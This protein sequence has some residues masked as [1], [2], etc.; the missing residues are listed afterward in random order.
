MVGTLLPSLLGDT[1]GLAHK[2]DGRTRPNPLVG[3]VVLD[4]QGRQFQGY[5]PRYGSVHAE[6]VALDLAG[7]AARGSTLYC[8]LEPCCHSGQGKHQP[9]CTGKIIAA[10]VQKVVVGQLDPN[11]QVRGK[12]LDQLRRAGIEVELASDPRPFLRLN[13]GFN[14]RH[15]LD[16]PYVHLKAALSL[17]GKI[18]PVPGQGGWISGPD[19]RTEV[20]DL[21]SRYDG[22]GVGVGTVLSD[23][24]Q[25]SV[26][27]D[28]YKGE[29]PRAV[30]FDRHLRTPL[31]S[32]LVQQRPGE[33]FIVGG[34]G[35]NNTPRGREL[36]SRGVEVLPSDG[37]LAGQL[38]ALAGV[39]IQTLLVEGGAEILT[40]FFVSELWDEITLYFAPK[41][42]G[43]GVPLLASGSG[44][45]QPRVPEFEDGEWRILGSQGIFHAYRPGWVDQLARRLPDVHGID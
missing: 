31:D 29:Q 21:R 45:R 6:A 10:G 33:T 39:S 20:H 25:L 34:E 35:A 5:H 40:Q 24:P 37:S 38:A 32:F 42:L 44:N 2:G 43:T 4:S 30:L 22:V 13:P 18:S 1:L 28:G 14:T 17:D 26:R 7:P 16:R 36:A 19:A 8:S 11:P 23:N 3:A 12:G 41:I 15:L 27:T 9:P